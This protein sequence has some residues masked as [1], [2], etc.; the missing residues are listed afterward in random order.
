MLYT[1]RMYCCSVTGNN[2]GWEHEDPSMFDTSQVSD[3]SIDYSQHQ[4][5]QKRKIPFLIS[6]GWRQQSQFVVL[7]VSNDHSPDV[8]GSTCRKIC[9][10]WCN[11]NKSL[12][13]WKAFYIPYFPRVR[14]T[15][16]KLCHKGRHCFS[17]MD[18]GDAEP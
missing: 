17:E 4:P 8:H 7:S 12:P 1:Y 13:A 6:V 15:H 3:Y 2:C 5:S 16:I 18:L 9:W 11:I 14:P 10:S